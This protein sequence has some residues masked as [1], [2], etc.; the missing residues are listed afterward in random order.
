MAKKETAKTW[1]VSVESNPEFCG[2]GAGGAQFAH[3]EA[4]VT[5]ERLANWFKC[6]KGYKVKEVKEDKTEAAAE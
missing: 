4:V 3:G 2:V 6:H 5:S 1:T